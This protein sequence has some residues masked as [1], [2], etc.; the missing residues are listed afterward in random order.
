MKVMCKLIHGDSRLPL[1]QSMNSAGFD[2]HSIEEALIKPGE[3]W[4]I[5]TGVCIEIPWGYE[6]QVRPRSSVGK[7]G[8]IIPN[9]PGTIDSDYRGEVKVLLM[10]LS[11]VDFKVNVGDR[12]A[13]IVFLKLPVA[14]VE[15]AL[16]LS[17][18]KRGPGGFGSTGV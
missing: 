16:E 7:K 2:L 8:V 15:P 3:I 6:G 18:T 13:Q 17:E 4:M 1:R 10:N 5:S 12:I 14:K 11:T 9:S